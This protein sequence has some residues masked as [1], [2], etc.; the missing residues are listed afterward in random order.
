MDIGLSTRRALV[1]SS[2]LALLQLQV[3]L[4]ESAASPGSMDAAAS[5]SNL[6]PIELPA[7][8]SPW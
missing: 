5:R 3:S 2:A 1:W 7:A 6:S 8:L 4:Q